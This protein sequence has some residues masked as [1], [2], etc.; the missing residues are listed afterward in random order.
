MFF[1]MKC[2]LKYFYNTGKTSKKL[3]KDWVYHF[4]VFSIL[5]YK[6]KHEVSRKLHLQHKRAK[7]HTRKRRYSQ[8]YISC[9]IY[10]LC[11][12]FYLKVF[13]CK[14]SNHR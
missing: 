4:L 5:A 7:Q 13:I 14:C 2:L 1:L 8:I 11:A 9:L 12:F 10:Q 3:E 6:Q